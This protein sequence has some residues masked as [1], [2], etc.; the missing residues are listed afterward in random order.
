MSGETN[1]GLLHGIL[2]I[3]MGWTNSHLHHFIADNI[4]YMDPDIEVDA[5]DD[6]PLPENEFCVKLSDIL[7]FEG[8]QLIYEYDFGDCWKHLIRVEKILPE[9]RDFVSPAVC[10]DGGRAC[11]PED[12]GGLPGYFDLCE[13]MQDPDNDGYDEL[14][15]WLGHHYDPEQF[16]AG[17]INQYLKKLK[18]KRPDWMQLGKI[19]AERDGEMFVEDDYI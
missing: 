4:R 17:R 14:Y 15:D 12:C 16:D 19:L 13:I 11:P 10:I 2:Q 3:S 7:P 5:F 6:E 1:L 18:W 8:D 9:H